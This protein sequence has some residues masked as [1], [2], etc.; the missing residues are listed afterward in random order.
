MTKKNLPTLY[1]LL[2]VVSALFAASTLAAQHLRQKQKRKLIRSRQFRQIPLRL[3]SLRFPP[4]QK[5]LHQKTA[6]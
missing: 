3:P 5:S 6:Q 1:A 2:L 4:T